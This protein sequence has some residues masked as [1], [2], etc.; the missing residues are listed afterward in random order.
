MPAAAAP[1]RL[2]RTV[3]NS[4]QVFLCRVLEIDISSNSLSH[5]PV[6]AAAAPVSDWLYYS[7]ARHH[8]ICRMLDHSRLQTLPYVRELLPLIASQDGLRCDT[9]AVRE[10]IPLWAGVPS[11]GST[12]CAGPTARPQRPAGPGATAPPGRQRCTASAAAPRSSS[13]TCEDLTSHNSG[14]RMFVW[15]G[16]R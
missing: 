16:S 7:L 13:S 1:V 12:V 6:P 15:L 14:L 2:P 8:S 11:C 4:N 3:A 9:A 5:L 10:Q